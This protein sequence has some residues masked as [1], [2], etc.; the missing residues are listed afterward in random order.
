MSIHK[1]VILLFH[2]SCVSGF[3]C[4][5]SLSRLALH[6]LDKLGYFP[7]YAAS[8]ASSK[9]RLTGRFDTIGECCAVSWA[10]G[11]RPL[12]LAGN[13]PRA[14]RLRR[15]LFRLLTKCI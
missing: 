11:R 10:G 15:A 12:T 8:Y 5:P 2:C 7:E 14:H 1:V 3:Y 13:T 9:N 6:G 4:Q